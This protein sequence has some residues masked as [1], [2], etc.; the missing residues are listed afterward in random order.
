MRALPEV[1]FLQIGDQRSLTSTGSRAV[2]PALLHVVVIHPPTCCFN[3]WVLE[4]GH[5]WVLCACRPLA[6]ATRAMELLE[7]DA[8][9]KGADEG[10]P[11]V[12]YKHERV[13]R[14]R[15]SA[16]LAENR[17]RN[18]ACIQMREVDLAR[19]SVIIEKDRVSGPLLERFGARAI[20][21]RLKPVAVQAQHVPRPVLGPSLHEARDEARL[22]HDVVITNEQLVTSHERWHGKPRGTVEV[23]AHVSHC[24]PTAWGG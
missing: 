24:D 5:L 12:V 16:G 4:K 18:E 9:M 7:P 2:W 8:Q 19:R 13:V 14:L 17:T 3:T 20:L 21:V 11:V 22:W 15:H 6:R 23:P 10:Q 1:H